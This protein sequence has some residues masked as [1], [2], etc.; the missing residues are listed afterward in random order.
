M[1][2]KTGKQKTLH[3]K[4]FFIFAA[5]LSVSGLIDTA[6]LSIS[7]YKNYTDEAYS[8]FCAISQAINCDTVSQSPWSILFGLPVS[9]WGV[10]GY[11]FYFLILLHISKSSEERMALWNLLF[12]LGIVYSSLAIYFGYISAAKIKSYCILCLFSYLVSFSLLFLSWIVLR[13]F[14]CQPFSR[15]LKSSILYIIHTNKYLKILILC[16]ACLFISLQMFIP[17]YW[18]YSFPTPANVATGITE[19]GFPWIGAKEPILT[20]EEY[21]D[22]QCF[23]CKKMHFM[24]RQLIS[25][26][27]DKIRLIHHHYPMDHTVNSIIVPTPFHV[28]SAKMAYLAIYAAYKDKFWQMNDVLYQ[29]SERGEDFNT[30]IIAEKTD[31]NAGELSMALK[32]PTIKQILITRYKKWNEA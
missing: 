17:Q 14:D 9:I 32:N 2:P 18:K 15:G 28:G 29:L 25:E 31:F 16:L 6:Y 20:I 24:L 12:C 7:H 19:E 1:H 10:F 30:K 13:R 21:S 26:Y 27:P 23:Q 5:L 11:L 3:Y 4:Y 8:S 22:Y